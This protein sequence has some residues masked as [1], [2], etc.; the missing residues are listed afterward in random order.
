MVISYMIK[1]TAR[2][3]QIKLKWL[4][5]KLWQ[6]QT[7]SKEHPEQNYKESGTESLRFCG[8]FRRF[9]TFYKIKTQVGPTFLYKLI[10]FIDN[11]TYTYSTH[12]VGT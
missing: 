10:P 12:S 8:C 7:Q 9:C 6:R 3:F 5:I 2:V 1:Q 4:V 11:N